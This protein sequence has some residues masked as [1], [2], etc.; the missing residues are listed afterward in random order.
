MDIVEI[1]GDWIGYYTFDNGYSEENKQ[2]KVPF[3]LTIK[4]GINEFVGRIYE[5]VDFG[6]I[7]DEI[8]IKGHQNGNEIEFTKYYTLE[9][10]IDENNDL[11]SLESEN[12]TTVY[13][14]GYFDDSDNKFKGDWEI[15]GLREDEDGIF[16]AD[17]QT[18]QWT[19]W[20]EG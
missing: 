17:N 10:L 16:H 7:D 6:G 19:I 12:P 15:T 5:E 18:G 20:R 14:K 4:R 13:Y 11:I 1:N 9:H 2:Q 3:R 8:V